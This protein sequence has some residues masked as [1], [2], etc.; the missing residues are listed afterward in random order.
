MESGIYRI[1]NLKNE[2]SY[3]G[4]AVD[5]ERRKFQHFKALKTGASHNSHLQNSWNKWGEENFLWEVLEI[6]DAD[7]LMIR[8]ARWIEELDSCN[9]QRGFNMKIESGDGTWRL[10]DETRAE[11]SR[12]RKELWAADHYKDHP[13]ARPKTGEN[14]P[15]WGAV[16][17]EEL[18]EKISRAVRETAAREPE[19][20]AKSD[21]TRKRMSAAAKKKWDNLS[22]E[23]R[24][25]S[26]E[27]REKISAA[28]RG[29]FVSEETRRKKSESM[30]RTL[31][32]LSD[33]ERALRSE[34]IS[35]RRKERLASLSDEE[36]SAI[37][38]RMSSGVDPQN[39]SHTE[40]SKK[41][42][43]ERQKEHFA[44]MS[45]EN[46]KEHGRRL[47]E[48]RAERYASMTDEE[49]V[50]EDERRQ[51][52][53]AKMREAKRLK[54]LEREGVLSE[55]TELIGTITEVDHG[56]RDSREDDRNLHSP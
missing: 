18:R 56:Q 45:E 37:G 6:C 17:D 34:K 41:N 11:W 44:T 39:R 16:I 1:R 36:R 50:I 52:L 42:I 14:N 13:Y 15:R 51:A 29:R 38:K 25:L 7:S 46:R 21:E 33:E 54:K 35:R 32:N 10:S 12:R 4:R 5:L 23:E 48:K 49:R 47:A 2:K 40:E 27:T 28:G 30:K 9:P 53:S 20:F 24:K 22:E 19:R 26:P 8:E 55:G 31:A 3:V 43:S